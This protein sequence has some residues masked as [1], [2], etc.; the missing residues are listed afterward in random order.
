MDTI[1]HT[2]NDDLSRDHCDISEPS[3]SLEK[4]SF[5]KSRFIHN[6]VTNDFNLPDDAVP[7]DKVFLRSLCNIK[8]RT[9]QLQ[10]TPRPR[11]P[12]DDANDGYNGEELKW[13]QDEDGIWN[14]PDEKITDTRLKDDPLQDYERTA[15]ANDITMRIV[16]SPVHVERPT[17]EKGTA[18]ITIPHE[19]QSDTGAN[20]HITPHA[21][22]LHDIR[23]FEPVTI[24][25]AQKD[26]SL[27]VQAIGTFHLK[28]S[29]DIKDLHMYYSPNAS[30][31]IVSPTAICRQYPELIGFHQST[32]FV[33]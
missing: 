21:H 13:E 11:Q 20:A 24:G 2:I 23:W 18:N 3:T 19:E 7:P 5:V 12:D 6:R 10:R 33:L 17:T 26:S 15:I 30:N 14:M 31:T 22:L 32:V 8:I 28:T 9:L 4:M 29:N 16:N 27:Q 1:I 25:N